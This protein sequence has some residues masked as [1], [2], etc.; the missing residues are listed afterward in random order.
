MGNQRFPN[1]PSSVPVTIIP[2]SSSSSVALVTATL[3]MFQLWP[4]QFP[5]RTLGVNLKLA[6]IFPAYF[7]RVRALRSPRRVR[8]GRGRSW[9]HNRIVQIDL[10]S[11]KY[12]SRALTFEA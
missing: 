5:A 6:N 12:R 2:I 7:E 10:V 1:L 11:S 9:R 3:H 8:L 4:F